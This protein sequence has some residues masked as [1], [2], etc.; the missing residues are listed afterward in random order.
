MRQVTEP[1]Y[2]TVFSALATDFAVRKME[3]DRLVYL[4]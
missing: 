3:Q 1:L 2:S 4:P